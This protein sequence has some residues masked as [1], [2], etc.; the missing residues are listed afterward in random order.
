V[1]PAHPAEL[2]L[3]LAQGRLVFAEL[4]GRVGWLLP[5]GEVMTLAGWVVAPNK[6][7]SWLALLDVRCPADVGV[8]LHLKMAPLLCSWPSRFGVFARDTQN[9]RR[10]RDQRL[11]HP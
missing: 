11:E 4:A 10:L 8:P 2:A 5:T 3:S 9:P 7:R 6:V 1:A